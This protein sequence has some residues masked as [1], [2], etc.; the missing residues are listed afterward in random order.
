MTFYSLV[1]LTSNSAHVESGHNFLAKALAQIMQLRKDK[2]ED[3]VS[4]CRQP[5]PGTKYG[6]GLN[7]EIKGL[8]WE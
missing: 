7:L 4:V 2:L 8:L 1:H 3:Q 5:T 6:N